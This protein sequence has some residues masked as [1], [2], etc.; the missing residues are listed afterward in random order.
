MAIS[1]GEMLPAGVCLY[2]A[3]WVFSIRKALA[4]RIYRGHALWIGVIAVLLAMAVFLTYST[5]PIVNDLFSV[6]FSVLFPL[7]F[8][9]IDSTIPVAR[10]SD[11]L[12]RP[13]LRW[14][15]TRKVLWAEA[16]ALAIINVL[17]TMAPTS[18]VSSSFG[19]FLG[20]IL[21]PVLAISLFGVS[22]AALIIGA[23]RSRDPL[24]RGSLKWLGGV[25]GVFICIFVYDT[26]L[27]FL[28]PSL[29]EYAFY[30][31]YYAVPSGILSTMAAYAL[32]RS[33]RALAPLNRV[34]TA[35]LGA[36]SG[37]TLGSTPPTT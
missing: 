31:S 25:L 4:G 32:Y 3:Y 9:V 10:R 1:V 15:R 14:D 30:Y 27:S 20:N 26:L 29:S 7:I 18:F 35:E 6:F 2:T 21:W 24:F 5:N 19:L 8:A 36:P 16:I 37:H 12:L 34:S 22:G 23:R 11:P 28:L 33:A 17:P 13:I